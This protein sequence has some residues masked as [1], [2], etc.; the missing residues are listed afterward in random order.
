MLSFDVWLFLAQPLCFLSYGIFISHTSP[1]AQRG[2]P[3][4]LLSG[5]RRTFSHPERGRVLGRL[6]LRGVA[7]GGCDFWM[8]MP[9]CAMD[10]VTLWAA[11]ECGVWTG[12]RSSPS[13]VGGSPRGGRAAPVPRGVCVFNAAGGVV[14]R[15]RS[16]FPAS[17]LAAR[18]WRR[19]GEALVAPPSIHLS[20]YTSIHP[21][22]HPLIHPFIHPPTALHGPALPALSARGGSARLRPR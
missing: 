2:D 16:R 11:Y 21:P 13:R 22:T 9:C 8:E 19:R 4:P 6:N 3:Q 10:K 14:S 5:V 1:P 7:A 18:R 15:G 20:I 12:M 17:P